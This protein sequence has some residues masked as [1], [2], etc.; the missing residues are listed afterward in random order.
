MLATQQVV[1]D[2]LKSLWDD[3]TSTVRDNLNIVAADFVSPSVFWEP[4]VNMNVE[5]APPDAP[6]ITGVTDN[7]TGQIDVAFSPTDGGTA[8]PSYT[9]TARSGVGP[10]VTAT[11]L[12]SPITVNGLDGGE[13]YQFFMTAT[14]T[15]GTSQPSDV[16]DRIRVGGSAPQITHP[17]DLIAHLDQEYDSGWGVIGFPAPEFELIGGEIPDGLTLEPDGTLSGSPTER[18]GTGKYT[19]SVEAINQ[20]GSDQA[21]ATIF[22]EGPTTIGEPSP[23]TGR[24][25]AR[26]KVCATPA[27]HGPACATRL[28]FGPFPGLKDRAAV[29]LVRGPVTYA[30]G[31]ATARYRELTLRRRCEPPLENP[32]GL[33]ESEPRCE[34]PFGRYTLVLRRDHHSIMV[35]VTLH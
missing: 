19:F 31:H 16:T 24:Q 34:V 35:P 32:T 30:T 22:V 33:M 18:G 1:W 13:E 26:A 20:L 12:G 28:L 11:G 3:P 6:L 9:V 27:S 17:P 8:P 4:I 2:R 23:E 21:T 15:V 10:D 29:S 14:N 25:R 5:P 7:G